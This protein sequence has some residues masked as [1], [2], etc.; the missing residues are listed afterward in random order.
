ISSDCAD[1][2]VLLAEETARTAGAAR[3]LYEQGV[4]A[5]E[6]ALGPNYF[7]NEVGSFWG[8]LETRPYMRATP[9]ALAW[10]A[11]GAAM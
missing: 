3:K 2:Y 1:A 10:L 11:N 6:R 8:L 9:G 7:R 5:G 4:A